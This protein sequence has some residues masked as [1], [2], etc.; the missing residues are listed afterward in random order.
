VEVSREIEEIQTCPICYEKVEVETNC[1]H[2]FCEAC[3]TM[4]GE[5]NQTGCPCCRTAL[6]FFRKI[7][8]V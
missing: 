6:V 2:R 8:Y 7:V 4:H 3:I 5:K 1:G